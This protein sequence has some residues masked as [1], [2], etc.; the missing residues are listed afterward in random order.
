M[1]RAAPAPYHPST[2]NPMPNPDLTLVDD[3]V[4]LDDDALT[5]LV[6]TLSHERAYLARQLEEAPDR[7]AVLRVAVREWGRRHYGSLDRFC[8][9]IADRM[10]VSI[11]HVRS[12]LYQ[13][14]RSRDVVDTAVALYLEATAA[15]RSA[16]A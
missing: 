7:E 5:G 13:S 15:L 1:L 9:E 14:G 10:D 11:S 6:T 16:S 12:S 2:T 3:V 8:V 4:D